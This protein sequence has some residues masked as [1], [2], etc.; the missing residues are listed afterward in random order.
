MSLVSGADW[1]ETQLIPRPNHKFTWEFSYGT[2]KRVEPY[3]SGK[4]PTYRTFFLK[5]KATVDTGTVQ[6]E[7]KTYLKKK[8]KIKFVQ[9]SK[10]YCP[11]SQVKK[12]EVRPDCS[13][14]PTQLALCLR[15]ATT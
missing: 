4:E 5:Q 9:K 14:A 15:L 7:L 6:C 12:T 3:C 10:T 11:A 2:F 13:Y 1:E 8:K